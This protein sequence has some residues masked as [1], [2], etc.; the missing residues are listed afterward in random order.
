MDAWLSADTRLN[1]RRLVEDQKARRR[2]IQTLDGSDSSHTVPL[3]QS[4]VASCT[5]LHC[6]EPTSCEEA[7]EGNDETEVIEI[8]LTYDLEFFHDLRRQLVILERLQKKELESINS[9]IV[10]LGQNL[11]KMKSSHSKKSKANIEVWRE[12]F[13]QY[14]D[15]QI[16]FSSNEQDAGARDAKR[17]QTQLQLFK[18]ALGMDRLSRLTSDKSVG[19]AVD[20]FLRINRNLLLLVKYQE[21]NRT[22]VLKILKKFSKQTAL[23]SQAN[24]SPWLTTAPVLAQDLAKVTYYTISEKL[25]QIIPQVDDYLCPVCFSISFK[26]VRLR[27]N[28]VFC[29]R[30][31]IV[32]QRAQQDHCPLC[33]RNVVM[34]ASS[35][36]TASFSCYVSC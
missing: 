15:S 3:D 23:Q 25:L 32:M 17:A 35:C 33:R 22:A 29:I 9:Q 7:H 24:E 16:F 13:R 12:I 11:Q 28:H 20:R 34:E 6:P 21:L 36:K 19:D 4:P 2:S 31:V 10:K 18:Q 30:C 27:C 14:L 26:P 1:L 5:R 8:P